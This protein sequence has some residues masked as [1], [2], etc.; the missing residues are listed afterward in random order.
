MPRKIKSGGSSHA[1]SSQ[2]AATQNDAPTARTPPQ[3][4][5]PASSMQPST[6]LAGQGKSRLAA[7]RLHKQL[8]AKQA[9]EWNRKLSE[10][11]D[12]IQILAD[13]T[14]KAL[15]Q[16]GIDDCKRFKE[17]K[18]EIDKN[19]ENK[20]LL[21]KIAI[22]QIDRAIAQFDRAQSYLCEYTINGINVFE[23]LRSAIENLESLK[24]KDTLFASYPDLKE[25]VDEIKMNL[26]SSCETNRLTAAYNLT[27]AMHER[28]SYVR[29]QLV[30]EYRELAKQTTEGNYSGNIP[31]SIEKLIAEF[32]KLSAEIMTGREKEEEIV[33]AYNRLLADPY[34]TLSEKD[35]RR[36]KEYPQK[37]QYNSGIS[38]LKNTQSIAI[39]IHLLTFLTLEDNKERQGNDKLQK[40]EQS[41]QR[42][43]AE[44]YSAALAILDELEKEEKDATLNTSKLSQEELSIKLEAATMLPGQFERIAGNC[45]K[46]A[47][48]YENLTGIVKDERLASSLKKMATDLDGCISHR[49]RALQMWTDRVQEE[50]EKN[51]TAASSSSQPAPAQ[52]PTAQSRPA[53][54]KSL[55]RTKEGVV[56]GRINQKGRLD[57]LGD[58]GQVIAT[59][60]RDEDSD[61]WVRDYDDEPDP[62]L[63]APSLVPTAGTNEIAA[64][65]KIENLIRKTWN[66]VDAST[67]F[68]QK[69]HAEV[70]ASRDYDDKINLLHRA[71]SNKAWAIARVKDAQVELQAGNTLEKD[72]SSP[73]A[74]DLK[75]LKEDKVKLDKHLQQTQRNMHIHSRKRRDPTEANFRFLW[76]EG[77][78]A[79][80]TRE[81]ERRQNR[82]NAADFLERYVVSLK[83]GPQG[84]Q[85]E[86]W[87]VHAHY[88]TSRSDATPK[89]VHMKRNAEKDWGVERQAYHSHPLS[90]K[91]FELIQQEAATPLHS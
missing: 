66:I 19:P 51:C 82:D 64:H 13:E 36:V 46:R 42:L 84:E 60:F 30:G 90:E 41:V 74:N 54:K 73:F 65:E 63:S 11:Y 22:A 14:S 56:V 72:C 44:E 85:Y 37:T 2:T 9:Q 48:E 59:Y 38:S 17:T 47:T 80:I 24:N 7:L 89:R 67:R 49:E 78:V 20:K 88:D 69:A 5:L 26:A 45:E 76:N 28:S 16:K 52:A 62:A 27:S 35:L 15:M 33:K 83:P 25:N 57:G 21:E 75:A 86:P 3:Q 32:D 71:F 70:E 6:F 31:S 55:H 18:K 39:K 61:N 1:R 68:S 8:N 81:W 4:G 29:K 43:L 50:K 87:I 58:T 77:Q 40:W 12:P 23:R 79:S 53:Q 10:Y 91:T 34:L